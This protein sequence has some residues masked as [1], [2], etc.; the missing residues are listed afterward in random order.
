MS[1]LERK[2][3]V[4]QIVKIMGCSANTVRRRFRDHPE[5]GRVGSAETRRK[6]PRFRLL[7]PESCL[8]KWWEELKRNDR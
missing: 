1:T 4:Q 6:R 5:V 7:I 8:Y 2:Y 3:T